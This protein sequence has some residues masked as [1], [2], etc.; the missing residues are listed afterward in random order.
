[1]G[2]PFLFGDYGSSRRASPWSAEGLGLLT[3]PLDYDPIPACG[4]DLELLDRH[5][6]GFF[7]I[8]GDHRAKVLG[9]PKS[10]LQRAESRHGYV[11]LSSSQHRPSSF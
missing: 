7:L 3:D 11:G 2:L 9:A 10:H 8:V 6:Y 5:G 1:M 4:L